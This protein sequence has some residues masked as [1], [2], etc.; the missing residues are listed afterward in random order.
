[1][2]RDDDAPAALDAVPEV[3]RL[4]GQGKPRRGFIA[5]PGGW[6]YLLEAIAA[7]VT[8]RAAAKAIGC[9]LHAAHRMM[10]LARGQ[11]RA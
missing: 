9:S 3:V 6:T 5:L 4:D 10:V 11:I 8:C 1:L 7:G 2:F